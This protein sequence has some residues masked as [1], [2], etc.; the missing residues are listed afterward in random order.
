[1]ADRAAAPGAPRPVP[2]WVVWPAF[3]VLAGLGVW[4][5]QR[6]EWKTALIDTIAERRAA[7][8]AALPAELRESARA[9]WEFTRVALAG[10][11][12]RD[13]EMRVLAQTRGGRVG[14]RVVAPFARDGGG[15]VLVDRGWAPEDAAI[16]RP[17]G[18]AAVEGL[19]R[20]AP[21][22]NP[23]RPGNRPEDGVWHWIDPPAMARAA[24]LPETAF[25]VQAA[26]PAGEGGRY[27][28]PGGAALELRNDHLQYALTWFGLAAALLAVH[29]VLR[30]RARR[31]AA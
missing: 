9:E 27:P 18:P 5:T 1:M 4:Q 26:G 28:I 16:D 31:G 12:L 19:L 6:L 2:G 11:F 29:A 10:R 24:G 13:A 8:P 14:V 20:G 30:R 7:P 25:Y 23:F 15:A 17:E 22:G 3:L 21:A